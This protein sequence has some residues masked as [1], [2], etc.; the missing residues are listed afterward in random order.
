M[1]SG[2]K[3]CAVKTSSTPPPADPFEPLKT[4]GESH[5]SHA[6]LLGRHVSA[7]ST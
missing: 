1:H 4:A 2:C 3:F 6:L 7:I 5:Y